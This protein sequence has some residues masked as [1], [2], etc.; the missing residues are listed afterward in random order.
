LLAGLDRVFAVMHKGRG[1]R[2]EREV[3]AGGAPMRGGIHPLPPRRVTPR[4]VFGRH[5]SAP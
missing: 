1:K 2:G 5:H 3:G 4:T